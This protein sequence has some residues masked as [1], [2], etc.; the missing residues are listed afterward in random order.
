MKN[1]KK[2][3]KITTLETSWKSLGLLWIIEKSIK[4]KY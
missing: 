4:I 2:T 3:Y 1:I